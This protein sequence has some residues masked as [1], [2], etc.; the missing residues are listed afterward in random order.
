MKRDR[1]I[2]PDVAK[3]KGRKP[4][5]WT[6]DEPALA[7]M[8]SFYLAAFYQLSTCRP[9][10]FN[11]LSSIPWT[12]I[13]MYADRHRLEHDVAHAFT[14]AMMAMDAAWLKVQHAQA[15]RERAKAARAAGGDD[16]TP[17]PR[18]VKV[19]PAKRSRS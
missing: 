10:S 8:D 2:S 15:E 19:H 11:G 1:E 3:R 13:I 6:T 5:A 14:Q 7:P 9:P 4:A 16:E 17:G 12:A 18:R